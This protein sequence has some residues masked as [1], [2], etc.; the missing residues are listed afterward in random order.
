MIILW[1]RILLGSKSSPS[2]APSAAIMDLISSCPKIL[3]GCWSTL[4]TFKILPFK[5]KIAWKLRS[6]PILADPPA[7]SPSTIY[8]S[9]LEGSRSAQSASLPGSE[10]PS[11]AFFRITSSRAFLAASRA[12]WEVRHFSITSLLSLG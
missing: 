7:D 4:S 1:Y 10:V 12:L 2:P 5:G 11:R 3:S 6:R 8:N 9:D